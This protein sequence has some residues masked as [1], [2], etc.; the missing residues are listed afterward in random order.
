MEYEESDEDWEY[1]YEGYAK[2]GECEESEGHEKYGVGEYD[3]YE[4]CEQF[5][6]DYGWRC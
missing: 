6:Y 2:N 3:E 5:L 1:E 4:G